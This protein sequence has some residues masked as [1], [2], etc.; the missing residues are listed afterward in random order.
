MQSARSRSRP[1]PLFRLVGKRWASEFTQEFR[2][3]MYDD[4]HVFIVIDPYAAV[5]VL[6]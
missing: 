4:R 3:D 6:R 5:Q 2:C 1:L